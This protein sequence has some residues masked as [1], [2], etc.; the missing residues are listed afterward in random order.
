MP[1]STNSKA[2]WLIFCALIIVLA[3]MAISPWSAAA[4]IKVRDVSSEQ[5]RGTITMSARLDFE[6]S[7]EALEAL[8]NGVALHIVVEIQT[9]EQR[10]WLWDQTVTEHSER[11]RIERQALSKNYLVTHKYRRRSFLS[12]SEA[13]Q[14]IGTLSDY[15]LVDASA[16]E[17][18]KKYRGRIRAWLDI[19]SLPPPMRPAAYMSSNWRL[20][21][22]WVEWPLRS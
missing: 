19:E 4:G 12:L 8:E 16:L 2:G 21:S 6:L 20:A 15:P 1:A 9:L 3:L 18:D 5:V 7:P 22:G 13:L 14:F 11:F 10:R 17:V